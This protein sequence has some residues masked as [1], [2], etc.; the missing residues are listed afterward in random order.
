MQCP[1][2]TC[3]RDR[4]SSSMQARLHVPHPISQLRL[5]FSS[6]FD[7]DLIDTSL[8]VQ[9]A[10][11]LYRASGSDRTKWWT[12]HAATSATT[13]TAVSSI[14]AARGRRVRDILGNWVLAAD[15]SNANILGLACFGKSVVAGIEIFALLDTGQGQ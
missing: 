9:E 6:I 12:E 7:S 14:L 4:V 2:R 1:A 5:S 13:D 11:L 15:L 10:T 8:P 3:H